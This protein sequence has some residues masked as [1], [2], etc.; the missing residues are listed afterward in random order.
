LGGEEHGVDYTICYQVSIFFF[1]LVNPQNN[2]KKR[3]LKC[4]FS[5]RYV[6][7]GALSEVSPIFFLSYK[8]TH[9]LHN[10]GS[11]LGSPISQQTSHRKQIYFGR[12]SGE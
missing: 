9:P 2:K 10:D 4:E 8:K 12:W 7:Y 6:P 3:E 1:L 5:F 11:V